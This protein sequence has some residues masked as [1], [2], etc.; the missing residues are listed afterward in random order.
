M[1][2]N[3]I[4]NSENNNCERHEVNDQ[5]GS[6]QL[7]VLQPSS[8]NGILENRQGMTSVKGEMDQVMLM[9]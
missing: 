2:W 5:F 6:F 7:A 1:K 8:A 4:Q 9:G 3:T